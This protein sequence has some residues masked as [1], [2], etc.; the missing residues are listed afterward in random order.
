MASVKKRGEGKWL[1]V[2]RAH[3]PGSGGVVQRARMF[4]GTRSDALRFAHEMESAQRR[5]PVASTRGL[6]LAKYLADWLDWR[7]KAAHAGV[8]TVHR[9]GQHVKVISALIGDRLLSRISARDLDELTAQ[10]RK[11]Y[12]PV[13]TAGAYGCVRKA[14]RQAHRWQLISTRP[15]EG[16]T[17]PSLKLASPQPPSVEET[18]ALA[19]RLAEAEQPIAAMLV[20]TML[21]TGA[22]KSELLALSWADI[23]LDRGVVTIAKAVFE[24]GGAYGIKPEPKNASSRRQVALPADCLARLRAHRVWTRELQMQSGRSWNPDDLVF[25]APH[26]GVWRPSNATAMVARIARRHGLKPGLHI[27]RHAHAV[28]LLEQ[29]VPI[30][31]VA[32]RLGHS[33]PAMTLRVYQH[34]TTRAE[35]LAVA[36]LDRVLADAPKPEGKRK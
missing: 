33:D 9:D 10:L 13:T 35:Q 11:R 2:W 30:K 31:V 4:E 21:A 27:Y 22:R 19:E 16:A 5:E 7:R 6:T 28:A 3:D 26:G 32:D 24:A 18:L 17:A 15:W 23:D 14:L 8:K 1:C 29:Q 20:H 25:P 34:V 12:A 36:A